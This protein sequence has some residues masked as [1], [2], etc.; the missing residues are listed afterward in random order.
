MATDFSKLTLSVH[1]GSEGD[2]LFGGMATPLYPSSAYDYL[3][4]DEGS[5]YPRYYNTPNQ[6]AVVTK[7][8][9]LEGAEDG[10]F[11]SSGMAAILSSVLSFMESG[12]HA[13]FQRDLYGGTFNAITEEMQ[14]FGMEFS[15]VESTDPDAFEEAIRSNTRVIYIETPSNP[16]LKITPIRAIVDI[17]RKHEL[18]TIIDNTFASPINQNPLSLGID[19]VTHSG[20]KYIGGHSDIICGVALGRR[21]HIE[22]I[23]KHAK[24]YGGNAD[25][26]TAWLVERSLK[27]LALRVRQQNAN[28]M[29]IASFLQQEPRIGKVFYPGLP[30][31]PGHDIAKEQM[32]GG[33]GGMLSFEV[34]GDP[35]AFMNRLKLISRAISLGGVETTITSPARTSHSKL[36]AEERKQMQVSDSLLR[37]SVGIEE[38]GDLIEDIRQALH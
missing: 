36:T 20:T 4:T 18:V 23:R 21:D 10:V 26:Y 12:K 30:G 24:N 29:A 2:P 27:T 7:L 9:A 19:I 38:G 16:T 28:A 14:R 17:A 32:T 11:F 31:H 37:L 6:K 1:A 13:V 35:D 3:H 34:P 22:R 33:F 15:F 25:A 8:A 5:I